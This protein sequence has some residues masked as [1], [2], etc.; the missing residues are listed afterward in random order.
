MT[1]EQMLQR[2]FEIQE[3]AHR[4]T[5]DPDEYVRRVEQEC[6]KDP[7]F[8]MAWHAH[9]HRLSMQTIGPFDPYEATLKWRRA[10]TGNGLEHLHNS[11]DASFAE[12]VEARRRQGFLYEEHT[13]FEQAKACVEKWHTDRYGDLDGQWENWCVQ[14][15]PQD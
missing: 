9:E 1:E 14:Q 7:E 11:G 13:T 4:E 10:D 12:A 6:I 5:H 2:L 15:P 8:R 3:A